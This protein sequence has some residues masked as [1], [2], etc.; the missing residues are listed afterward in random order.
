M[1]GT[2]DIYKAADIKASVKMFL[3]GFGSTRPIYFFSNYKAFSKF[4]IATWIPA[5][6][7]FLFY[8]T[9]WSYPGWISSPTS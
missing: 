1:N 5:N 9:V 8:S 2:D 6:G 7:E 3:Y 4:P